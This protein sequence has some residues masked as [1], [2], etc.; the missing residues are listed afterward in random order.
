[1]AAR[2]YQRLKAAIAVAAAASVL[3][4]GAYF[5][6]TAPAETQPAP[7][8]TTAGAVVAQPAAS[9]ER[10]PATARPAARRSRGS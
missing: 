3:A 8:E 9:A 2:R 10:Q 7:V 6:A 4:G 5:S 1:M